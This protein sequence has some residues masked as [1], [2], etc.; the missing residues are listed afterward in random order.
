MAEQSAPVERR[1]S[2]RRARLAAL[3]VMLGLAAGGA[4][5][6]FLHPDGEKLSL[7][8]ATQDPLTPTGVDQSIPIQPKVP[9]LSSMARMR[10]FSSQTCSCDW[11]R[12]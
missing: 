7:V 5:Y 1:W 9:R 12:E 11:P 4:G 2:G 8:G 10:R 3:V 6:V